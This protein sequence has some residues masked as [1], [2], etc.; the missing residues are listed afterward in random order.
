MWVSVEF[1]VIFKDI[2]EGEI[3][4]KIKFIG[5]SVGMGLEYEELGEFRFFR[6]YN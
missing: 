2:W 1:L 4:G 5:R 3:R 6:W